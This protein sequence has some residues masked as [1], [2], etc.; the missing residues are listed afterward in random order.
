MH[1]TS[2][3]RPRVGKSAAASIPPCWGTPRDAR[4]GGSGMQRLQ[5]TPG[6]IHLVEVGIGTRPPVPLTPLIGR[7]AEV[8]VVSDLLRR[9]DVRLVTL[10]G[11]GGVGK[12]RL[13]VAAVAELRDAFADGAIFVS[14]AP[15]HDPA[16]VLPTLAQALGL[17]GA[18]HR[19]LFDQLVVRLSSLQMLLVFDNF[20]QVIDG[21][22]QLTDLLLAC[23]RLKALV[24]SRAVLRLTG[25]YD[26]AIPPLG[27]P[28]GA[29]GNAA[30]VGTQA[31]SSAVDLFVA[32]AR[33]V[34][35]DF[36][37]TPTNAAAVAAICRRLD[38][39]PLA[40]ELAA[41]RVALLPPEAMLTRLSRPLPLL[42]G[43]SRDLPARQ[44]T[45]R[46]T[47]AWSYDLLTADEQAL[48]R[49]LSVCAGGF[50]LEYVERGLTT[51]DAR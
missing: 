41:A 39:L 37:L 42:T 29:S 7:T 15:V 11:P 34:Q 10:T 30:D 43:G 40:I 16:L 47:I 48:F 17:R 3:R 1:A 5:G 35:A 44:R 21:A 20:E 51:E 23:P 28:D 24:T 9:E 49:R 4:P 8:Q 25:E 27:L 45:M 32:R 38:G 2:P 12:T 26:V 6:R 18:D 22:V 36:Q 14:L 31:A 13:A 50:A 33:A 46:N 19:P